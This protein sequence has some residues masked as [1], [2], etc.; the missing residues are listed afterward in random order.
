MGSRGQA[1]IGSLGHEVLQKLKQFAD[2]AYRFWLQKRSK[3]ENFAHLTSWFLTSRPYVLQLKVKR[4][5]WWLSP[6]PS[7]ATAQPT[8]L[9]QLWNNSLHYS[10]KRN[11]VLRMTRVFEFYHQA[12]LL[13][14]TFTY[15]YFYVT[16]KVV[17]CCSVFTEPPNMQTN[18]AYSPDF[19]R[20]LWNNS[21]DTFLHTVI[22]CVR[23]FSQYHRHRVAWISIR[24]F[25]YRW[26]FLGVALS[27]V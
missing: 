12:Q 8:Y 7:A 25:T 17:I 21:A 24:Y 2:I 18:A 9:Q 5:I 10:K 27:V 16:Y 4:P 1:S 19:R 15:F 22:F 14:I 23:S 20:T 6:P 26:W 11:F 3:L 13:T